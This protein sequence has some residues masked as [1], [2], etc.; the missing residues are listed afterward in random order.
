MSDLVGQ[1]FNSHHMQN[2]VIVEY[3]TS[4]IPTIN[5]L[6]THFNRDNAFRIPFYET[7][8]GLLIESGNNFGKTLFL[9]FEFFMFDSFKIFNQRIFVFSGHI[10]YLYITFM[11]HFFNNYLLNLWNLFTGIW[12]SKIIKFNEPSKLLNTSTVYSI[13]FNFSKIRFY[14]EV[15]MGLNLAHLLL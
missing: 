8:Q 7:N 10:N 3:A 11:S 13:T 6:T 12:F 4:H 14:I 9:C 5:R 15:L 2:I 1:F